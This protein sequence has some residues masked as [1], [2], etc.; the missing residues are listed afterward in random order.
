MK[1][2]TIVFD[3]GCSVTLWAQ[4]SVLKEARHNCSD[5]ERDH[6]QFWRWCQEKTIAVVSAEPAGSQPGASHCKTRV[7]G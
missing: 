6:Q 5:H 4:T 2:I 7:S 1:R 3:C